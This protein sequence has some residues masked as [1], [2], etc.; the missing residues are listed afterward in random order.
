MEESK[1]L[2]EH[3]ETQLSGAIIGDLKIDIDRAVTTF[4]QNISG[5]EQE[6]PVVVPILHTCSYLAAGGIL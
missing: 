1:V 3:K 2:E 4:L 6:Y 5:W